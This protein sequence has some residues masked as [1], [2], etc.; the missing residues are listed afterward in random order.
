M[1][2]W[3]IK[4][5][6]AGALACSNFAAVSAHADDTAAWMKDREARFAAYQAAHPNPDAEIAEIKAKTAA[7]IAAYVPPATPPKYADLYARSAVLAPAQKAQATTMFKAA[8][9]LWQAGDFASAKEGFSQALQIDPASGPGNYYLGDILK[10]ENNTQAALYLDRAATLA[11][12]TT[13]AFM[14]AAALRT[15]PASETDPALDGAPVIWR[16]SDMPIELWDG[17]A[18]PTMIVVP[19]GDYTMGSPATEPNH[20]ANESPRHRVRIGYSFA[21]SKY[22]ITVGEFA[23]FVAETH[24]DAGNQCYTLQGGNFDNHNGRN[25][26]RPD[27]DQTSQSPA[28]CMN[29]DDAQ[30]YVA[31]LSRKTG[32][33]YRLLSEA[34]YEYANR[35]GSMTAYW[36]GDDPAAACA[37]AN[38]FD[39]DAKSVNPN[40]TANT[41]HDG[42]VFTSPVGSFKPNPFGLY[43]TTGNVWSWLGDCGNDTYSGAPTDGSANQGGDCTRRLLRGGSWFNFPQFL[44]AALRIRSLSGFRSFNF[45]FRVARTL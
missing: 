9:G 25:W 23:Q 44:R 21:A 37:Y 35:A 16:T 20:Q 24:Y 34:E 33:A 19:A 10:R 29:W 11:P 45:G 1:R 18:Y 17:A 43:D 13:E 39:Q 15:L 8:F 30:A 31:W 5:A 32:H 28:T 22:P 42:Y 6:A 7:M 26:R 41:C 14:A 36:W 12:G 38:G 4:F 3:W 40:W 2:L 27:F